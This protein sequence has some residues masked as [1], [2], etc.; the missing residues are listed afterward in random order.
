[1]NINIVASIVLF[2]LSPLLGVLTAFLNFSKKNRN[3]I[4]FLISLIFF[5]VFLK[6]PPAFDA[7]RYLQM[8][9][10]VNLN[11]LTEYSNYYTFY[12]ICYLFKFF[13]IPFYF[14]PSTFVFFY[15]LSLFKAFDLIL[16]N[17]KLFSG[18]E[19]LYCLFFILVLVVFSNP[20]YS[21]F[22]MR[23]SL[24]L[25]LFIYALVCNLYNLKN[26]SY[27]FFALSTFFHFS[28][29]FLTLFFL[30]VNNIRISKIVS[31]SLLVIGT[32]V[33][34]YFLTFV[35]SYI[36]FA[37]LG[38][39]YSSYLDYSQYSQYSNNMMIATYISYILK[40]GLIL[41][42]FFIK[43]LTAFDSKLLNI[44]LWL[45]SLLGFLSISDSAI[46]RFSNLAFL[47]SLLFIFSNLKYAK[48]KF[49]YQFIIFVIFLCFLII[50]DIYMFRY[51]IL[52][53]SYIMSSL[54]SPFQFLFFTDGEYRDLLK[55]LNY[56]GTWK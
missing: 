4:Y 6:S 21:S 26:R 53:G 46:D 54:L 3:Y 31:I 33:S 7:I 50:L 30:L 20:I 14:I 56:D 24:A 42:I 35:I 15:L 13:S 51:S 32:F 22:V 43:P 47:L 48:Y 34:K 37:S 12:L 1:M 5:L 10:E 49:I 36:P 27:L 41:L 55:Y 39:Q 28:F 9:D 18:K 25:S 29:G 11:T 8:Y 23:N 19:K 38:D 2:I 45:L 17:K 40:G 44:I 16:I 52:K